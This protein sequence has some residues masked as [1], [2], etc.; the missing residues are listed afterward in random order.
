MKKSFITSG[1][2]RLVE[3]EFSVDW[4]WESRS[5]EFWTLIG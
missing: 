5:Q 1:P 4:S 2:G 3:E